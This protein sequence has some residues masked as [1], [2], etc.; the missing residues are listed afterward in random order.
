MRPDDQTKRGSCSGESSSSTAAEL[1]NMFCIGPDGCKM[2]RVSF[3]VSQFD[4]SEINVRTTD[5]RII[6]HAKH[7]ETGKLCNRQAQVD[8]KKQVGIK[9]QVGPQDVGFNSS[10]YHSPMIPMVTFCAL[11]T[12]NL[13]M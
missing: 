3:D 8:L 2:F 4:P 1:N 10:Y 11:I 7:E 9:K 13:I 6:V 12:N 5:Q